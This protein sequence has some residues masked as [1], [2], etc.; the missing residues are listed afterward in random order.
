MIRIVLDTNVIVSA[1]L[2]EEGLE[3]T[4]FLLALAGTITLCV[5]QPI[6]AEYE[7]VLSRKKFS[8][9]P[10]RV[11]R[12]LEKIRR[13]SRR[14]RPKRT[15]AECPD[16]EDNRFLECAEAARAD[17]L[18]TGNKR[19]FPT[20]WGKTKVVNAREFLEITGPKLL[21]PKKS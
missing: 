19:H 2:H 15:L 11:A 1:H 3:A 18:I 16:P 8:L 14:V 9:D 13:A 10:P 17:Y 12:S 5:S 4:V 20:H 6:L 21:L 7:G